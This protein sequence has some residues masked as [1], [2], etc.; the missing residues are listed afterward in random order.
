MRMDVR[1]REIQLK[2]HRRAS[3]WPYPLWSKFEKS[4]WRDVE[5]V[6]TI[7][8]TEALTERR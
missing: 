6:E 3:E 4:F 8:M 7:L 5:T 2:W 1:I